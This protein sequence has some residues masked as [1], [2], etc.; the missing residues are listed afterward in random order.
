MK[1]FAIIF[2]LF[3]PALAL[4]ARAIR[5]EVELAEEKA[6]TSYSFGMAVG[7]DLKQAGLEM[8]YA[9]FTEGLKAV[10]E[11]GEPRIDQDEALEIV[12]NAF[13]AAMIRQT[14]ELQVREAAFLAENGERPGIITTE[15]GL[16][17]EVFEEGSGPSPD[18]N[19]TVRVHYEGTLTNGTIF[20]SSHLL[21]VPE[22]I[23][24]NVVIPGWAEGLQLMNVGSKYRIYIPS[25]LA[26]G[27]RG[28]G[29]LIP[30][31]STLVFTIELIE[32][33]SPETGTGESDFTENDFTIEEKE[34]SLPG[35]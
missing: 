3:I 25:H 24:L 5:E 6:L 31:Y 21:N 14:T 32:I 12:Q 29:Q 16:Q 30:P 18:L 35:E 9:A 23:P 26:Y 34:E 8:D 15:S 1:H 2:C 4:H 33:I 22:E 20:D 10:M 27:E 17:Y 11:G 19:D 13:E 28:A 7:A